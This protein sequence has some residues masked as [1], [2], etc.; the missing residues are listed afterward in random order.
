MNASRSPATG[1]LPP[2][3]SDLAASS[4]VHGHTGEYFQGV[5]E[6][7]DGTI[8]RCLV[9]QRSS[10]FTAHATVHRT[11]TQGISLGSLSA[12]RIKARRAAELTF[13]KLT[14][15]KS[16]GLRLNLSNN[17]PTGLGAGSSSSDCLAASRAVQAFF[18][19]RLSPEAEYRLVVQAEHASDPLPF[20]R[21]VLSAHREGKVLEDLGSEP[22]FLALT[23]DSD[24]TGRGVN[25]DRLPRPR[26]ERD[27][28]EMFRVLIARLG[29]A[30]KSG[31]IAA[32]AHVGTLSAKMNQR[33]LPNQAYWYLAESYR[34]LGA[35]G[36]TVAHSGTAASFL[37][38][39]SFHVID[40]G[41]AQIELRR[42]GYHRAW[43]QYTTMG[44][45]PSPTPAQATDPNYAKGAC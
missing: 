27:E 10:I 12:G 29:C 35:L 4:T 20:D 22:R 41:R 38:D 30:V 6:A 28:I 19:V 24:P 23:F 39:P 26:Y 36:F 21:C 15:A 32:I 8:T 2:A 37:F 7:P 14:I 18:G 31:D 33:Y 45:R 1:A 25:T 5:Y 44:D 13:Q 42:L 11:S 17:I 43:I 34:R 16:L 3:A 40:L 9:T